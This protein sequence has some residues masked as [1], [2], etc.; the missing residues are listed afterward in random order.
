MKDDN[1][2]NC[3][4]CQST[5]NCE[6]ASGHCWCFELPQVMPYDESVGG[7]YCQKCLTEL[8]QKE[9]DKTSNS[10]K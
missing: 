8:I 7:C 1:N 10:D 5:V 2:N 4:R 3:P 6:A 9:Q